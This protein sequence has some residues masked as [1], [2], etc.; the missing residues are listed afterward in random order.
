MS[1]QSV[2]AFLFVTDNV[3][4]SGRHTDAFHEAL[5]VD[6]TALQRGVLRGRA[7]NRQI[8]GAEFVDDTRDEGR[9]RSHD[10]KVNGMGIHKLNIICV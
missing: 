4:A 2:A 1:A 5:G 6:F 8:P 10:R 7:D 9:F 3:K